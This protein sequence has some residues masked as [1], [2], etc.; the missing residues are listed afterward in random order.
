MGIVDEYAPFARQTATQYRDRPIGRNSTLPKPAKLGLS[1]NDAN[2]AVFQGKGM[3]ANIETTTQTAQMAD[4]LSAVQSAHGPLRSVLYVPASNAKAME[5]A[6]NLDTDALIFDLEDAVAPEAKPAARIEL[7]RQ[8]EQGG[9]RA[10]T[11]I[12]RVNGLDSAWGKEDLACFAQSAANAILVPKIAEPMDVSLAIDRMERHRSP[13]SQSLWAMMETPRALLKLDNIAG[14]ARTHGRLGALV[15]GTND[16]MKDM[17]LRK[18]AG[19][20]NL[21]SFLSLSVAAARAYDLAI[22]DGVFNDIGDAD[23]FAAECAQGRELGFDGKTLIHPSQIAPCEAAFSPEP[24]EIAQ[25]QAIIAAFEDPANA[26]KGVL[27]V[28]GKM[29]ERLHWQ[30][31]TRLLEKWTQI[32]LRAD[33]SAKES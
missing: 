18:V 28:D 31:A 12:V 3:A 8:L 27:K 30:E 24:G 10:A 1:P 19:R 22:L 4:N 9:F 25:A 29:A 17:R 33:R 11:I 16:I 20:P 13:R 21:L 32:Q 6:R 15:M 23:G 14:I 26:G 2:G 5:K 7:A